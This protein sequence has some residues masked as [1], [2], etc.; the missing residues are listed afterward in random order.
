MQPFTFSELRHLLEYLDGHAATPQSIYHIKFWTS[1]QDQVGGSG[2][3]ITKMKVQGSRSIQRISERQGIELDRITWRNRDSIITLNCGRR[4]LLIETDALSFVEI[5]R[6]K[7][8][9]QNVSKILVDLK[10]R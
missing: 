8:T 1:F 10:P 3:Y 6:H 4:E 9:G 5:C 2:S 7:L